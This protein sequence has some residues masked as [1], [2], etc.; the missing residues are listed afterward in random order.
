MGL[1]RTIVPYFCPCCHLVCYYLGSLLVWR[2]GIWCDGLELCSVDSDSSGL[3]PVDSK[4]LWLVI[5]LKSKD[6]FMEQPP[7]RTVLP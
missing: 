3:C 4:S 5:M 2:I 1:G 6:R 7:M